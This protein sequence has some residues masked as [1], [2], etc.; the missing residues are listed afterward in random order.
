MQENDPERPTWMTFFFALSVSYPEVVQKCM[1]FEKSK[2]DLYGDTL[3][4]LMD[5]VDEIG[6]NLVDEKSTQMKKEKQWL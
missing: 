5:V 3:D 4:D 6:E 1:I 2:C